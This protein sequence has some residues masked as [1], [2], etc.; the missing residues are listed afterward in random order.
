MNRG[1]LM[2]AWFAL[3]VAGATVCAQPTDPSAGSAQIADDVGRL[4]AVLFDRNPATT[5]VMRLEAARRLVQR[6]VPAAREAVARGLQERSVPAI[7]VATATALAESTMGDAAFI[8]PLFVLVAP[9]ASG[10]LARPAA[11][12]L[13]RY[14]G[15]PTVLSRLIERANDRRDQPA[16]RAVIESLGSFDEKRAAQTLIAL[17]NRDDESR[18]ARNATISA[19]QAMTGLRNNGSDVGRWNAWWRGNENRSDVEFRSAL[20]ASKAARYDGVKAAYD[21]LVADLPDVLGQAYRTASP[22]RRLELLTDWLNSP[23][24]EFRAVG[25]MIVREDKQSA[26]VVPEA[27]AEKLRSMVGDSD[28]TVRLNVANAL[29]AM[30]YAPAL[31]PML[32]QLSVEPSPDVR[33]ALARAIAP[34]QDLSAVPP[35]LKLLADE[36]R[37]VARAAAA[38]M[39]DLGG[40]LKREGDPALVGRSATALRELLGRT[41]GGAQEELREA[42]VE[43]MVPLERPELISELQQLLRPRET[44]RVRRS[45]VKAL[46]RFGQDLADA[47]ARCLTDSDPSVRLEAAQALAR[48]GRPDDITSLSQRLAESIEP[49]ISVR[50]AAW[51]AIET[52]LPDA[53]ADRLRSVAAIFSGNTDQDRTRRL[54]V[55]MQ[56]QAKYLAANDP[57]KLAEARQD[58]GETYMSFSPQQ[59]GEAVNYFKLA[60]D[61]YRATS[62]AVGVERMTDALLD[63]YLRANRFDDA[64]KFGSEA[65]AAQPGHAEI[66][67]DRIRLYAQSLNQNREDAAALEL[68]AKSENLQPKLADRVRND[69][70]EIEKEIRRRE[71]DGVRNAATAPTGPRGSAVGEYP[72]VA[73]VLIS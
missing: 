9:D 47:V 72:P 65:I 46:A 62:S 67:A 66:V 25:A 21:Q 52:I 40:K 14:Q 48:I 57:Q 56:L 70:A 5:R 24:A 11:R 55:L 59:A 26:A 63:A 36:D 20:I 45:A 38:A 6:D 13:S 12:A 71:V 34:V 1:V 22:E 49:D 29:G 8:D 32:N 50:E 35:L 58:I 31:E 7:Q 51:Q 73:P 60:L 23:R 44:P 2:S 69:L 4:S 54:A 3:G 53:S 61:D 19:L 33:A 42:C 15:D 18:E 37:S 41:D 28:E 27:V 17:L 16:R 10:E 43:A 39:K 30:N 64:M 68:I